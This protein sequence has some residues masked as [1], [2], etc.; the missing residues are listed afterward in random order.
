M[1]TTSDLLAGLAAQQHRIVGVL[2][3]LD[4]DTMHRP[5][6]PSGWTCAG[7]LQH[8]TGMTSFWFDT[9]MGGDPFEPVEDDFAV[10]DGVTGGR[11]RRGLHPGDRAGPP[12]RPR[13]PP[14]TLR[15][16]WWPDD[17]FGPW[18]L[19]SLF[20]VLQ[21]VLVETSTHAGHLDAARELIDG[22]TWAHDLDRLADAP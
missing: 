16:A 17:L 13:S 12:S 2:D 11:A 8:L 22:R 1:I 9:V 5:I 6:L 21:H 15:P 20:E 3:G 14:S 18:R 7:M 19:H 10:E 4:E